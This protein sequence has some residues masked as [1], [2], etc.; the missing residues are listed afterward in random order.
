MHVDAD[1][2]SSAGFLS[3]L[4]PLLASDWPLSGKAV[5]GR[6]ED[7]GEAWSCPAAWP[8]MHPSPPR[9]QTDSPHLPHVPAGTLPGKGKGR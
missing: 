4:P 2:A 3:R 1:S 8:V 5:G 7:P 6:G 9:G